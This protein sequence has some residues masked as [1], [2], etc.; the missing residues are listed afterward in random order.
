MTLISKRE[1]QYLYWTLLGK[2]AWE[3]AL[4]LDTT[5]NTAAKMIQSATRKLGAANKYAAALKAFRLGLLPDV[6]ENSSAIEADNAEETLDVNTWRHIELTLSQLNSLSF[7]E[8]HSW[9]TELKESHEGGQDG[10]I[11]GVTIWATFFVGTPVGIQWQWGASRGIVYAI[12]LLEIG[13]NFSIEF[14]LN[15][16]PYQTQQLAL[17]TLVAGIPWQ[18]SVMKVIAE[19]PNIPW[20]T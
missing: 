9:S 7:S 3:T 19:H 17:A 16:A 4:I 14:P 20:Q 18:E 8:V 2:T 6:G 5:E 11:S 12:D 13:T 10:C 1:G 15:G